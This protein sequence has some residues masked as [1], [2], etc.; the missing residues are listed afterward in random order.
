M[1]TMTTDEIKN[2]VVN[3]AN[4]YGI[5]PNIALAQMERES[6]WRQDVIFG[7]FV[8]GAGERG[9][10]QFTPGTWQTYGSGPH[11]NAYDP[12]LA[13][14]AWGNYMV[15]LMGI[16]GGNYIKALMA[17]NGGPGH[18]TNPEKY[19]PPSQAAQAYAQAIYS[20]AGFTADSVVNLDQIEVTAGGLPIWLIIGAAGLLLWVALSD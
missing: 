3:K 6:G 20:Q 9:I 5:N 13:L 16:F 14:D 17:Y 10:S 11:T 12:N 7:P 15:A 8:G 19:G 4:Q 18:L 2:L 1:K